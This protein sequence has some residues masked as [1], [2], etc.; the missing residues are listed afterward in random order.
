MPQK[1]RTS[2]ALN[3]K[4]SAGSEST[5]KL[6]IFP[7]FRNYFGWI[8]PN[9]TTVSWN[10]TYAGVAQDPKVNLFIFDLNIL[11]FFQRIFIRKFKNNSR[12]DPPFLDRPSKWSKEFCDFVRI[13][14]TKDP[15]QRPSAEVL[16]KVFVFKTIF[17]KNPW[18][19]FFFISIFSASIH[20][21]CEGP[22]TYSWSPCR[23]QG[24]NHWGRD[25][26]C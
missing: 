8:C 18:N 16:L 14:L 2:W 6:I 15:M 19:I 1:Y 12:S 4:I 24:W 10:V 20:R 9:G 23:I 25:R 7:L 13:C 11:I 21:Q 26:R 17:K 5:T 3:T 22:Q